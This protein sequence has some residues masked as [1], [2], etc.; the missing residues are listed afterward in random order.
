MAVCS[1]TT[2]K[3]VRYWLMCMAGIMAFMLF[4]TS[5]RAFLPD[6]GGNRITLSGRSITPN[7]LK[8]SH[9]GGSEEGL[10]RLREQSG[11]E[12][13]G[14]WN[15]WGTIHRLYVKNPSQAI[16]LKG[17]MVTDEEIWSHAR[18][19]IRDHSDCFKVLIGTRFSE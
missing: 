10:R 15:D 13:V 4:C 9:E 6:A 14:L 5:A 16:R 12:W 19:I 18:Q 7:R 17:G 3:G 2:K 1:C 11:Q 8:V